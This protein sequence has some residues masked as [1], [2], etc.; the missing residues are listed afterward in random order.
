[1]TPVQL[2]SLRQLSRA[3]GTG[4]QHVGRLSHENTRRA[5]GLITNVAACGA[6]ARSK[7]VASGSLALQQFSSAVG[8]KS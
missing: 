4:C 2:A 5:L 6:A 8:F 1:M 7:E 3:E